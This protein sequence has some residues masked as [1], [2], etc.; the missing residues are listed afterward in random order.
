MT[1]KARPLQGHEQIA[2]LQAAAVGT[3]TAK[4]D[5]AINT[6]TIEHP[7]SF[8]ALHRHHPDQ[9]RCDAMTRSRS[10]NGNFLSPMI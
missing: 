8:R 9:S 1:I 5:I 3:D 7:G 10:L 4:H 2:C 6:A